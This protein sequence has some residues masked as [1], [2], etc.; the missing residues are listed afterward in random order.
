MFGD[1]FSQPVDRVAR[2]AGAR[3]G[4]AKI[5]YELGRTRAS[6]TLV[7]EA[8]TVPGAR[9]TLHEGAACMGA[10][11]ALG[12]LAT[13]EL[14]RLA[15]LEARLAFRAAPT[16][17]SGRGLPLVTWVRQH[18]ERG[19]DLDE[20][21]RVAEDLS[22]AT[23]SVVRER[24]P[25][26]A[27][28]DAPER[29]LLTALERPR[30]LDELGALARVSRFRLLSF[31]HFLHSVDAL[32]VDQAHAELRVPPSPRRAPR[33]EMAAP[34]RSW[35][36]REAALRLLGLPPEADESLVKAAYRKL[37]RALHPDLHPGVGEVQRRA[38]EHRLA[39]VNAAYGLLTTL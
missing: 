26:S 30:R 33:R 18:L 32:R 10:H 3:L 15:S 4:F 24:R 35:S 1:A 31:L 14:D 7:A 34:P 36:S 37:A 20:A 8:S 12:R 27:L 6:G 9:L 25:D 17:S 11:D 38:L 29:A 5:A 19:L 28:L 2:R 13:A 21:H 23:L 16:S 39:H 22:G